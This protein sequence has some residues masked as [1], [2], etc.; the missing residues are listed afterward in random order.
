VGIR[1]LDGEN[2]NTIHHNNF[3]KNTVQIYVKSSYGNIW[4]NGYPSGGNYWSDYNGSDCRNGAD[5]NLA[6]CDGFGDTPKVID[7]NNRD[8][9]PIVKP[10]PW[11]SDD[12]GIA[13]LGKVGSQGASSMKTVIAEGTTVHFSVFVMNYGN[14]TETF[15]VTTSVDGTPLGTQ[16]GTTLSSRGYAIVNFTWNTV[17]FE[18]G[19]YMIA[20]QVSA[21][22]G[23]TDTSDNS[24]VCAVAIGAVGDVDNNGVVNM[25]DIY[26]MALRFGAIIGQTS[27]V[28]NY[29]IDD[30]GITNM[31]D[32]YVAA[33]HY[34]EIA[35]YWWPMFH[36]D[37]S[38]TGYSTSTAPSISHTIWNYTKGEAAISYPAI[39]D[40]RAYVGS[41][42]GKVYA[43]GAL[44]CSADSVG[45]S[46]ATF[47]LTDSVYV[48]GEGFTANSNVRI[49]SL[50]DGADASPS[51]AIASAY[52]MTNS[53][54]DIPVTL[55]RSQLLTRGEYNMWT[56]VSQKR[57]VGRGRCAEKLSH[58]LG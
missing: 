48:R 56:D 51:N 37:S 26:N 21:V 49:Y 3:V 7:G 34:G 39:V 8:N 44:V 9:Y 53:T 18:K 25:L 47:D 32:L 13:C 30:N 38:H 57:S 22:L 5:Q 54:G 46:K 42:D 24:F 14:D 12:I 23:E 40:G 41:D 27:Y 33:I 35:H 2:T 58:R 52:A 36:H 20:A 55:M 17:S 31:L 10:I 11:D 19:N 6:G 28:S 15:N 29:D 45:N 43:F 16:T 4:D 50:P 1:L